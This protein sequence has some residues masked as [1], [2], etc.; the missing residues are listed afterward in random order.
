MILLDWCLHCLIVTE[1]NFVHTKGAL[2]DKIVTFT[3]FSENITLGK[4]IFF[5]PINPI[6]TK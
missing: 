3:I 6:S 4:N 2:N 1:I 5:E